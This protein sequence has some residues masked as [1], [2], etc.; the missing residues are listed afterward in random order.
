MHVAGRS[1]TVVCGDC[2]RRG[3]QVGSVLAPI[4]Y[5]GVPVDP[6]RFEADAVQL[7]ALA[8]LEPKAVIKDGEAM[9]VKASGNRKPK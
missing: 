1:V 7:D 8:P 6:H 9:E 2:L 5:G 3:S 4:S